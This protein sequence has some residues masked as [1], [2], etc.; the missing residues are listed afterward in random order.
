MNQLKEK[1]SEKDLQLDKLEDELIKTSV[2][3]KEILRQEVT[4]IHNITVYVIKHT[5]HLRRNRIRLLLVN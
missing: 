1:L 3:F 4:F 5:F 2:K